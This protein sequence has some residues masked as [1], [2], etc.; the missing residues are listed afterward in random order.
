MM[1]ARPSPTPHVPNG[2]STAHA[3]ATLA[4]NATSTTAAAAAA[5]LGTTAPIL[6]VWY[7]DGLAPQASLEQALLL[8]RLC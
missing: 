1:P 8:D 5:A 4:D 2:L 3:Q 6:D 7:F